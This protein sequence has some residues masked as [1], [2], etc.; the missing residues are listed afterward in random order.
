MGVLAQRR[1]GNFTATDLDQRGEDGRSRV[2]QESYRDG[3]RV[4]LRSPPRARSTRIVPACGSFSVSA[5]TRP[6]AIGRCRECDGG[7]ELGV[8]DGRRL[9]VLGYNES[10]FG[11]MRA[12]RIPG[13]PA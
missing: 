2:P 1:T 5:G 6:A 12:M 3:L 11:S 4:S 8:G 10:S 9:G 13:L 7:H